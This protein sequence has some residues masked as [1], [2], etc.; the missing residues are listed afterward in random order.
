MQTPNAT[1]FLRAAIDT[2]EFFGFKSADELRNDPACKSCKDKLE[3][4]DSAADRKRDALH[5]MLTSGLT[6]YREAKLHGLDGPALFYNLEKVPRS[7]EVGVSFHIFDVEKSIAEAILIQAVR[8]LLTEIGYEQHI[9]RV[10]SL[11]DRDSS[12][13]YIRELTNYLRKRIDHMPASARELMKEHSLIA[14]MHLIEKGDELGFRSPSPLEYLSD[15]S[16]KHFREIVEYL[17]MSETPYEIDPKLMGHH[18]CYSDAVF[19]VDVHVPNQELGDTHSPL[20]VRGGRYSEFVQ[21]ATKKKTPAAGAVVVLRERKSPA[22][23]PKTSLNVAPSVYIVQLGFGP[24]I[25]SLLLVDQ[26]RRAGIQVHQNLACDSLSKQ[27][28]DAE[29]RKVRHTIIIGQKEYVDGTV[30]LRDMEARSQESIPAEQLATK[31]KRVIVT[32]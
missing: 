23:A 1:D 3:S 30:I 17:D 7:G 28:R 2:A 9:V 31:L 12:T 27:L 22:R 24:K 25:K 11:G 21:R 10:N 13:R 32:V 15:A 6:T 26:L 4:S 19:E 16:R 8:S 29:A 5:G 14:L 18:E 20:L